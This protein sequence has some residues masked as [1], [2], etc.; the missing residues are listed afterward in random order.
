MNS[1]ELKSAWKG[2]APP[3]KTNEEIK[4]MLQENRHPVLKGI[5]KQFTIE[6]LDN[7]LGRLMEVAST[8]IIPQSLPEADYVLL[9]GRS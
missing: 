1:D 6:L 8:G 5:R 7:E 3:A 9:R 4:L 2:I